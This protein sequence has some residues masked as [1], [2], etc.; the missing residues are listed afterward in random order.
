MA[1]TISTYNSVTLYQTSDKNL[2]MMGYKVWIPS[3][4]T[5]SLAVAVSGSTTV[6]EKYSLHFKTEEEARKYIDYCKDVNASADGTA[7]FT[8]KTSHA[9]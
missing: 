7:V 4:V 5:S 2:D 1:T 9:N 8:A 6:A 3:T